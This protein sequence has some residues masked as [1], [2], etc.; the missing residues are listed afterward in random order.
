MSGGGTHH[1]A[2]L[3]DTEDR[4]ALARLF[5]NDSVNVYTHDFPLESIHPQAFNLRCRCPP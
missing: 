2:Q 1:R 3:I 5:F 4:I